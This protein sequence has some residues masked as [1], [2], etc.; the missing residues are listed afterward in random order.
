MIKTKKV[1]LLIL[2]FVVLAIGF[3]SQYL[4]QIKE[5]ENSAN[6]KRA[7][8]NQYIRQSSSFIELMTVY[9]N[10][11]MEK[12]IT[13]DDAFFNIMKYNKEENT[14]NMDSII[15]I[16]DKDSIGNLTGIG[17]IPVDPIDKREINLA[18]EY[19]VFFQKINKRLPEIAW[20]YYTSENNFAYM[21]PFVA[22]KD[23]R[24][25]YNL[26]AAEFYTVVK[27]EYNPDRKFLW[28]PV[29]L[30]HAGK[31]LM[32]SVSGPIYYKNDFKG[33]VSLD[34]TVGQLKKMIESKY[35][36][37]LIDEQETI[38]TGSKNTNYKNEVI[39]ITDYFGVSN[40]EI[41]KMKTAKNNGVKVVRNH[42]VYYVDFDSAPWRLL[43]ILPVWKVV[44]N[45]VLYN[46]P[47]IMICILLFINFNEV[48]I[49]KK[50]ENK[51]VES[52][53]ELKAY[54]DKLENA[55][56]YDFLTAT[57][58]RRGFEENFYKT[59]AINNAIKIPVSFIMGDIDLFKLFN[60]TYGHSAGDMVLRELAKKMKENVS[61]S[62][63]VCRWGGEEFLIMLAN[64]NYDEALEIAEK[65][66]M[67]IENMFIPWEDNI[68]L[69]A[70]VTFGVAE[71]DYDYSYDHGISQADDALYYGKSHGRNQVV[72]NRQIETK[73]KENNT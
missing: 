4:S 50:T 69:K 9:G 3:R 71:Y 23:F 59:I 55:A 62:D 7:H 24:Y 56:K 49:R 39:S 36:G 27:P 22:S 30:D 61:N 26:K 67:D 68:E 29:Y 19:N 43:V 65:I 44:L 47:I 18:L 41:N 53:E 13:H 66:R 64:K 2:V 51:L 25:T 21:Y 34:L 63:L 48:E 10:D 35:E 11:Y 57:Y 42:F 16:V 8:I 38:I 20:L 73:D 72:G 46:L 14:Y 12:E 1:F 60:D 37:Y 52:L 70:T 45:A 17:Q 33:V 32:V 5:F 15:G 6:E 28:T 40:G 54:Q 58:N 31:G